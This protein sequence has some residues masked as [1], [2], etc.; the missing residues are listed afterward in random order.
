[1]LC[2]DDA[3]FFENA[4]FMECGGYFFVR[5]VKHLADDEDIFPASRIVKNVEKFL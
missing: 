4:V 5:V 1:M 3:H 2:F